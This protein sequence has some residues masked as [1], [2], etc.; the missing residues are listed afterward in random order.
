MFLHFRV[1]DATFWEMNRADEGYESGDEAYLKAAMRYDVTRLR[2]LRLRRSVLNG[3]YRRREADKLLRTI[4]EL[5]YKI[6]V[7]ESDV[8]QANY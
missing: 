2:K 3:K 1:G 6:S 4:E 8:Y 5:D 7:L